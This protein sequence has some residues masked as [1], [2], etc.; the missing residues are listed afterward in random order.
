L[1][2]DPE[3]Q[4]NFITQEANLLHTSPMD[5]RIAEDFKA[6]QAGANL[7][8]GAPNARHAGRGAAFRKELQ[9]PGLQT[10]A[11]GKPLSIS[12]AGQTLNIPQPPP[13][14]E[15]PTD[16]RLAGQI[17]PTPFN[18]AQTALATSPLGF[19]PNAQPTPAALTTPTGGKPV[20]STMTATP[21]PTPTPTPSGSGVTIN[22]TPVPTP[23]P[24]PVPAG[25]TNTIGYTT[26]AAD[27]K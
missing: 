2:D 15:R 24:T 10:D 6:A 5:P 23:T 16:W 14:A 18:A 21:T 26:P 20:G 19:G 17:M 12:F 27:R 22:P 4:M 1:L 3:F 11:Q 25:S 9:Y 7:L 8:E 13:V